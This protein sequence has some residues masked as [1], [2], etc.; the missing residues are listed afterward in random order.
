MN[1]MMGLGG[2]M[3]PSMRNFRGG[4]MGSAMADPLNQGV[5]Q[6]GQGGGMDVLGS[7]KAQS[8]FATRYQRNPMAGPAMG[9]FGGF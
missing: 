3:M 5:G 2:S 6:L 1:G 4:L 7:L 9:G 8:D